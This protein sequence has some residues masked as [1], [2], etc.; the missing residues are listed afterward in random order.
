MEHLV[1]NVMYDHEQFQI[2]T[3]K[4]AEDFT[5]NFLGQINDPHYSNDS[6]LTPDNCHYTGY[7]EISIVR[8][9]AEI[10]TREDLEYSAS[11]P[12]DS[13]F[14]PYIPSTLKKAILKPK[15]RTQKKSVKAGIRRNLGY[16]KANRSNSET[17]YRGVRFSTNGLR[18]RATVNYMKKPFNVGTFSTAEEAAHAYDRALVKITRGDEK[19]RTRLNFPEHFDQLKNEESPFPPLTEIRLTV[20]KLKRPRSSSLKKDKRYKGTDPDYIYRS[21]SE[22]DSFNGV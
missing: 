5:N 20:D 2:L 12:S 8:T 9:C 7:K 1:I 11:L 17:G 22:H 18:F 21:D 16:V 13:E 6:T 10:S 4:D 3:A 19:M 15:K 14:K